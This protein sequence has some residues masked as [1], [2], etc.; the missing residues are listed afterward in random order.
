MARIFRRSGTG[1]GAPPNEGAAALE[2]VGIG[3]AFEIEDGQFKPAGVTYSPKGKDEV[4]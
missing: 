4:N 3:F 2:A 1:S